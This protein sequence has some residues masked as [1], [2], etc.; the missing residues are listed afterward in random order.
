MEPYRSLWK[1]Q[2]HSIGKL[3][4]RKEKRP[5]VRYENG[6]KRLGKWGSL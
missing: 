3:G 1:M 5:G 2:D 6:R 4:K